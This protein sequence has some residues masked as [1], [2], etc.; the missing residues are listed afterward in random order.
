MKGAIFVLHI[1]S[2][3]VRAVRIIDFISLSTVWSDYTCPNP[4]GHCVLLNS[5]P[6]RTAVLY[7]A[8]FFSLGFN[9]L[10]VVLAQLI[11]VSRCR[12]RFMCI[13]AAAVVIAKLCIG[14]AIYVCTPL[15]TY[16][17]YVKFTP[18]VELSIESACCSLTIGLL[19]GTTAYK[20]QPVLSTI[21]NSIVT[22]ALLTPS[23]SRWSSSL[24][25]LMVARVQSCRSTWRPL[26]TSCAP[27]LGTSSPSCCR[28]QHWIQAP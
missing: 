14:V 5:V 25:A 1:A 19:I 9:A 6:L 27:R 24:A 7:D 17:Q 15:A 2:A 13:V 26:L 23:S 28:C 20:R 11:L 22:V 18:A 3:V 16:H 8:A 12:L 21:A 10:C 4:A